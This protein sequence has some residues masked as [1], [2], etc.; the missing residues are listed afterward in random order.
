[1]QDKE[2]GKTN[3]FDTG[4]NVWNRNTHFLYIS[5]W[6]LRLVHFIKVFHID[7]FVAFVL[8]CFVLPHFTLTNLNTRT[9]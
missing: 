2:H 6:E 9:I 1:M 5:N 7:L 4:Q 3:K 8:F